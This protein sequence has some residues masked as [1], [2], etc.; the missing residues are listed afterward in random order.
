LS[1]EFFFVFLARVSEKERK[2]LFFR[3]PRALP[4]RSL[5]LHQ[6]PLTL[7]SPISPVLEASTTILT[8]AFTWPLKTTIESI[9]F[10]TSDSVPCVVPPYLSFLPP[11]TPAPSTS[12]A[13]MPVIPARERASTTAASLQGRTMASTLKKLQSGNAERSQATL[14]VVGAS[15]A[16]EARER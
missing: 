13:V 4:S 10:S 3:F 2:R 1:F 11:C 6:L 14:T 8:T 5:I 15:E 7:P 12:C 16:G 9:F